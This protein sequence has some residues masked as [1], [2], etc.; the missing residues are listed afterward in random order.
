[1]FHQRGSLAIVGIAPPMKVSR[2]FVQ[3]RLGA[4]ERQVAW[5]VRQ[6]GRQAGRPVACREACMQASA[7]RGRD[8]YLGTSAVFFWYVRVSRCFLGWALLPALPSGRPA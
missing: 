2:L 7:L 1:M 6:A 3:G 8:P 4:L 5:R